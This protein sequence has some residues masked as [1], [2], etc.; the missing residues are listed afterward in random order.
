VGKE[1]AAAKVDAAILRKLDPRGK[2]VAMLR[3]QESCGL[4][5]GAAHSHG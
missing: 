1:Y 4:L 2:L 5:S 3:R